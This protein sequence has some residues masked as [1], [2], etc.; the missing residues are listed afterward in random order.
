MVTNLKTMFLK[1]YLSQTE[2]SSILAVYRF[3]FGLLMFISVIRFWYKGWIEELYLDPVFHFSYFGFE[4]VQPLGV[5]T[6]ILFFI[7]GLSSL[8]ICIGFK[9]RLSIIIFFF[10]FLYIEMMDK[11]T[12]L[13]HYYF[14]SLLSFLMIF[15]PA[16]A[17]FSLD[18]LISAKSY[19]YI[20]KW[21]I[22]SIKLLIAIVYIYA[23]LAKLNSDWL[24]SAMPLKIWLTSQYDTPILGAFFHEDWVHYLM[25]WGGMFYD[26]CI[27]F[28][29]LFPKTRLLGFCLVVGFHVLTKILFP[30][31]MFP[32][33]MIFSATIFFSATFHSSVIYYLIY[34]FQRIKL[35]FLNFKKMV[36]HNHFYYSNTKPIIYI[37]CAFFFLQIIIPF[38]YVLYPG[39]LLWHEQGYRF[40]WRVML[41]E[42][43]GIANFKIVNQ[44]DNTSF[45]VQNSNFLTP[46]QEKQMSFQPDLIL[47]FAHFLGDYY[48]LNSTS[49][50]QVFVDNYVA[51]NGRKS[52]MMVSNEVDLYKEKKTFKNKKWII[53]LDDDIKG[54]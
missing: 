34:P 17:T 25:S 47:D 11:T 27:P 12:Y 2:S 51:L 24:I 10:S 35:S 22:D 49:H 30:I 48:S 32:F 39:E 42:K 8:F 7:C 40:S 53:P 9:Y 36:T 50:V 28:L 6:Y 20:P 41:V 33:I 31:G 1:S 44:E 43:V 15:L 4:W 14:V 5:Y 16:N 46:Y 13:N 37:Y 45:Y 21:T 38:R 3:F 29:L 23:A 19:R 26:F 18:S 52:Q 54:L